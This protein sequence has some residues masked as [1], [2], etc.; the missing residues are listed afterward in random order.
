MRRP[1]RRARS[2]RG[3][4]SREE[5]L[6][7]DPC[8]TEPTA[9]LTFR[10]EEAVP[11]KGS[12]EGQPTIEVM[13]LNRLELRGK[14]LVHLELLRALRAALDAFRDRQQTTG[15]GPLERGAQQ[16]L[17]ARLQH[18]SSAEGEYS[19]MTGAFFGST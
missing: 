8:A 13:G 19:S 7:L 4:L 1:N 10:D 17:E 11:V 5:P 18:H 12:L 16:Q 6:L 15:L 2:H 3:K 14:R 9:H